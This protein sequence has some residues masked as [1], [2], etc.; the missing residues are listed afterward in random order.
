MDFDT[1]LKEFEAAQKARFDKFDQDFKG[2]VTLDTMKKMQADIMGDVRK[3]IPA[4]MLSDIHR[5]AT[6]ERQ[7]RDRIAKFWSFVVDPEATAKGMSMDRTAAMKALNVSVGANMGFMVPEEVL[8]EIIFLERNFNF[9]AGLVRALPNA[10]IKFNLPREGSG[11][12]FQRGKT[13]QTPTE[14]TPTIDQVNFSLAELTGVA[15]VSNVLLRYSG[16]DVAAYLNEIAARDMSD[17]HLKDWLNGSGSNEP[18]GIRLTTGVNSVAAMVG[19][20]LNEDDLDAIQAAHPTKYLRGTSVVW[21]GSKNVIGAG[22]WISRLKDANGRYLFMNPQEGRGR[23]L[24]NS[25]QPEQNLAGYIKGYAAYEHPNAVDTELWLVDLSRYWAPISGNMEVAVSTE[26]R[27][28]QNQ[29]TIRIWLQDD[30]QLT[31]AAAATKLLGVA[32]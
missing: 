6:P 2:V 14:S 19:A 17:Q 11:F 20:H 29:S 25:A 21:I 13:G 16:F 18:T 3:L 32:Q 9:M 12:T 27:F 10:P 26:A 22:G 4:D 28:V 23:G 8:S 7:K 1:M 30:G 5:Q 31:I 15:Y 24:T